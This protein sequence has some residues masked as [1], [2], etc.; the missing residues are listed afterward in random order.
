MHGV[1]DDGCMDEYLDG[2]MDEFMLNR[3]M[4]T[5]DEWICEKIDGWMDNWMETGKE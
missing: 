1:L 2:W 5:G 3:W 4:D